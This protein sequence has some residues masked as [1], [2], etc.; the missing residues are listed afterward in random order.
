MCATRLWGWCGAFRPEFLNRLDE[1]ILFHRLKRGEMGPIVEIQLVGLGGCWRIARSA[2][3]MRGARLACGKRL[4]PRL[5][6]AAP[7]ARDPAHLQDPLAEMILAGKVRDGDH[8][9][10]SVKGGVL[11]FNG[12]PPQTADIE[13]FEPRVP[14]RKLH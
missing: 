4:G 7:Q 10:I 14:K 13:Q 11:T 6:G 1:I 12:E 9:A 5:W 3:A 2:D 8:V